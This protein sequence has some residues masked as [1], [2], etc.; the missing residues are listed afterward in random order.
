MGRA[1]AR[2]LAEKGANV[3]IVSRNVARLEETL[4]EIKV[5][6]SLAPSPPPPRAHSLQRGTT[7]SRQ[8]T[9]P[10]L[11]LHLDRRFEAGLC[12]QPYR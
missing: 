10:A 12:R 1:A 3:I 6:C 2:Q 4:A 5:R 11:P 8:V 9:E 7:G